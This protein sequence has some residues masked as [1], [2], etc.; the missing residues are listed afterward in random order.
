MSH[1]A[2]SASSPPPAAG[3][4]TADSAPSQLE[5]LRAE[6]DALRASIAETDH[7]VDD[8]QI[9][10]AE[11]QRPWYRNVQTLVAVLSLVIA[12]AVG[13]TSAYWSKAQTD[14]M[15]AQADLARSQSALAESRLQQQ[16]IEDARAE[17]RGLLQE[18]T[19]LTRSSPNL[20]GVDNPYLAQ[21]LTTN[22]LAEMALL[23]NQA[24]DIAQTIPNFVSS[25]EYLTIAQRLGQL[26]DFQ[27]AEAMLVRA[28]ET[29]TTAYELLSA[30]RTYAIYLFGKKQIADART[31]MQEALDVWTFF[32]EVKELDPLTATV[33]DLVTRMRWAEAEVV[34][35]FCPEAEEH[36]AAAGDIMAQLGQNAGPVIQNQYDL[37]LDGVRGNCDPTYTAALP[38]PTA[39]S[40]VDAIGGG[41]T[42]PL[43]LP[44]GTQPAW[45]EP[46]GTL[47]AW[48]QPIDA[49]S[50]FDLPTPT[51]TP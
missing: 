14:L 9:R 20:E 50:P 5:T 23:T 51:V 37:M 27:K 47:P 15:S 42:S 41:E 40:L 4:V 33:E 1:S 49:S 22:E 45:L 18:L 8:L 31:Q 2:E 39:A 44:P 26:G 19:A 11:F 29:A 38:T 10:A 13:L 36:A 28:D 7:E 21:Y 25:T 24:Y 16:Q 34:A 46:I 6:I 3:S 48:L 12:L 30:T 17:L 43:L 32:P 35:G